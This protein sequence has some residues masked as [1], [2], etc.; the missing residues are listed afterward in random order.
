MKN[1]TLLLLGVGLLG[2]ACNEYKLVEGDDLQNVDDD[3]GAPDIAVDPSSVDF[4]EVDVSGGEAPPSEVSEVVTISN[5]GDADLHIQDIY[6]A[7]E[8]GPYTYSSVSSVLVQPGSVAQFTVM[9]SPE[10]AE[11]TTGT[12]L[13]ESDDPDEGTVEVQL[14]GTGIAPV[15]DVS[16][17]EYDF[18]ELYIGCDSA[19]PVTITNVGNADLEVSSFDYNTGSTD[20]VFDSV[21][22]VNGALPWVIAQITS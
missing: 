14:L 2:I 10:T 16:P 20:L 15:I 11:E 18:G 6:L 7:D 12:V 3:D 5:E 8:N 21:E 9:F 17:S 1:T 4:G 22:E 13:I 19:Q